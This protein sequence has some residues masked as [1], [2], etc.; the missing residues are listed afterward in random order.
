MSDPLPDIDALL[1]R[2]DA[3]AYTE[4]CGPMP[5]DTR[6]VI[7]VDQD[8]VDAIAVIKYLRGTR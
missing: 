3:R 4:I 8:L 2:L 1:E 5:G 7:D 6:P